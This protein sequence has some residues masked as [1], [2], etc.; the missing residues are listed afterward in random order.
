MLKS[1]GDE[2]LGIETFEESAVN[3]KKSVETLDD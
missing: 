3:M 1:D 2:K